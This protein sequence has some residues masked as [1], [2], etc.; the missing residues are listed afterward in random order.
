MN[1]DRALTPQERKKN[2]VFFTLITFGLLL[3]VAAQVFLHPTSDMAVDE[4]TL[5]LK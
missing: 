4:A 3:M 5:S 1:D 2:K